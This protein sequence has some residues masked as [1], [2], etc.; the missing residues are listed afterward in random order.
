[1]N[2][3]RSPRA[4]RQPATGPHQHLNTGDDDTGSDSQPLL[5]HGP[6]LPSSRSRMHHPS[7]S[8]SAVIV[9][10]SGSLSSQF[11]S[12]LIAKDKP[13]FLYLLLKALGIL[14]VAA[15]GKTAVVFLTQYLAL[16]I[17]TATTTAL[18]QFYCASFPKLLASQSPPDMLDQR[19]AQDIDRL[20]TLLAEF[21]ESVIL[22]PALIAYYTYNLTTLSG[23]SG[24]A[25]I[26]LYFVIG[27]FASSRLV[28]RVARSPI[29]LSGPLPRSQEQHRLDASWSAVR[30]ATLDMMRQHATCASS[31]NSSAISWLV[32]Q[33]GF[34]AIYLVY[35]LT[36]LV[37]LTD[38]VSDILGHLT[39][40]RSNLCLATPSGE[41]LFQ[42]LSFSVGSA[43]WLHL[44]GPNGV[45][46]TSLFRAI[47][48]IWPIQ[49]ANCSSQQ[50]LTSCS[51]TD[52]L[53]LCSP[54]SRSHSTTLKPTPFC[55]TSSSGIYSNPISTWNPTTLCQ[56]L[57]GPHARTSP[58]GPP[59]SLQREQQ[60]LAAVRLLLHVRHLRRL[61]TRVWVLVDEGVSAMDVHTEAHFWNMLKHEEVAVIAVSHHYRADKGVF[62]RA[63][64][65]KPAVERLG[66]RCTRTL[67]CDTQ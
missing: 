4:R 33:N 24:P 38:K 21:I 67:G 1:M 12:A 5:P 62:N 37:S 27:A 50:M 8:D 10:Q 52:Q 9:Y 19:I 26:Y 45:G 14:T 39:R 20:S 55:T 56:T 17:R 11:Y 65:L 22:S 13:Q 28:D 51:L 40:V 3:V 43:D 6:A 18:H 64:E 48:G 66:I 29:T 32:A 59:A 35:K 30:V 42:D 16:S 57:P 61:G 25:I 44:S 53:I 41:V 54:L 15:L 58:T 31:P 7:N 36:S 63:V 60:R 47:C 2:V 46:K 23:W 34:V 49:R